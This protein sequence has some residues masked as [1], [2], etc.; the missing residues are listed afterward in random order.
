MSLNQVG[1]LFALGFAEVF[2]NCCVVLDE[3]LIAL[4]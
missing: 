3:E 4:E 2:P 1:E